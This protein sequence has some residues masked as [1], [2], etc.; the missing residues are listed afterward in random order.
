MYLSMG[1]LDRDT[2]QAENVFLDFKNQ[3]ALHHYKGAKMKL[4]EFGNFEHMD[5]ALP[6]FMKG[7]VFVFEK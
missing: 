3:L 2:T 1:S 6:G 5:A 7:L 4:Q